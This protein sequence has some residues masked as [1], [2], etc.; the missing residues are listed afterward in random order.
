MEDEEDVPAPPSKA[1]FVTRFF[2]QVHHYRKLL[3][4]Y[5][6]IPVLF[7]VLGLTIERQL[8]KQ[9]P[10]TFVSEGRMIV[11]ARLAIPSANV[12][13]EEL[14]YFFGT[15]VA[16]MQS[17][18]VLSRVNL[19]LNSTNSPP[20][21]APAIEVT[22]FPKTSIY[23]L[24]AVGLDPGFAQE[25]LQAT[26]EEYMTLK[27]ELLKNTTTATES[28][29]EGELKAM[30]TELDKAKQAIL[31][32]QES[33]SVVLIQPNG[34]NNAAEYLLSLKRQLDERSSEL[35]LLKTSTLDQNLERI[36]E[37]SGK[38]GN[39]G[40]NAV[41]QA[42]SGGVPAA[43]LGSGL[44]AT[45]A[46]LG[47]FEEAYLQ[48]KQQLIMVQAQRDNEAKFLNTNS[49]DLII[50]NKKVDDLEMQLQIARQQ[51]QDQMANR[52]LTL[53]RQIEGLT[54]LVAQYEQQAL[55][56]SKK[57]SNFESLKEN[58]KR[59][60]TMY[61][62]MQAN[63]HTLDVNKS[64][65]QESVSILQPAT[66]SQP[67]PPE[68][69]KHMVM[70][71]LISAV[72]GFGVLLFISLLND[73]PSTFTELEA[74]FD[75][76]VLGQI[77]LVKAKGKPPVLEMDDARYPLVESYRS[78]RSALLYKDAVKGETQ[79]AHKTIVIASAYPSDGKSTTSANFAITMAHAGARVLLVDGDIHRG[80]LHEVFGA[81]ASPGLA[82][83]LAGQRS[84]QEAVVETSTP[85]LY[86]LPRGVAPKQAGNL[87]ARS[88]KFLAEVE[89]AYD[90][91][92][93]DSAPVLMADDVLTLAPQ[94]DALI[95]VIRAAF[96]SGRV[97]KAALDLLRLR[98]VNVVGLVFNAVPPNAGDYYNYRSK[99]YYAYPQEE[100]AK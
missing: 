44:M 17:G 66:P 42:G 27:K 80:V 11:N 90:Y 53:E 73:R 94:A 52:E 57:L 85:G 59:L 48:T 2:N 93:F 54:N 62:Q 60:Q 68:N 31:D 14:N 84:W 71:G 100:A 8:L 70:A 37:N 69:Q 67:V 23:N 6:W 81:V 92:I 29:M 76:P 26:M 25:Y 43:T 4:K 12:Y 30:G 72:L 41:G 97:A 5:W 16:L 40:T 86:L 47:G 1:A 28:G 15:Q 91:C 96:T 18:S 9:Q 88:G 56:V 87:F 46:N 33:N 22:L 10:L 38:S 98:R 61:D 75:M 55:D 58:Q 51:S 7:V 95:M 74:M 49:Q 45:P 78:L 99:K 63:L 34:G 79:N 77:P 83:V 35:L 82:E 13:N 32:F 89:V 21:P 24:K 3:A 50:L 20:R 64:I 65:G 19:R 39:T 36:Q